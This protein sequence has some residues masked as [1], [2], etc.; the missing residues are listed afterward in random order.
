MRRT[1][2]AAR[3]AVLA[4]SLIVGLVGFA[5][6]ASA[7]VVSVG[8]GGDTDWGIT[9]TATTS[10]YYPTYNTNMAG[11]ISVAYSAHFLG[12]PLPVTAYVVS[13]F[14]F[15]PFSRPVDLADNAPLSS[16]TY[17]Y[18]WDSYMGKNA[19]MVNGS[20]SFWGSN[21]WYVNGTAK[22]DTH[23]A[24]GYFHGG[25]GTGHSIDANTRNYVSVS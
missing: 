20:G 22:A 15:M 25:T 14:P 4:A 10:T 23:G 7:S 3:A 18:T 17:A 6:N 5:P 12:I 2:M 19:W 8:V 11:N 9:A 1:R 13:S 16:V 21:T 24:T